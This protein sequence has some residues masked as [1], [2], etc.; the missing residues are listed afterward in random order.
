M[1]QQF[2]TSFAHMQDFCLLEGRGFMHEQLKIGG[3]NGIV[4]GWDTVRY[5]KIMYYTGGLAQLVERVLSMHEVGSSILPFSMQTN[6]FVIWWCQWLSYLPLTQ[7]TTIWVYVS[8]SS[9]FVAKQSK[10]LY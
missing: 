5:Q 7:D 10:A 4:A 6:L 8:E 1:R 9:N 2:S 3:A